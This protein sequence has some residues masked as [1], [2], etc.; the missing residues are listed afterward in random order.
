MADLEGLCRAA[1]AC[2]REPAK[3]HPPATAGVENLDAVFR[4]YED[5]IRASICREAG[6][7]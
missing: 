3:A 4:F 5:L 2:L 7:R 1:E 6:K